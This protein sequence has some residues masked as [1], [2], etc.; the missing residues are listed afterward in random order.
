MHLQDSCQLIRRQAV[1]I[2]LK[3]LKSLLL[4]DVSLNVSYLSKLVFN[5]SSHLAFFFFF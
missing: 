5:A 1:K 3:T 4:G 2:C